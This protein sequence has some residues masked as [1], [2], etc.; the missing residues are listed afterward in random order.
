MGLWTD[1][2]EP[3]DNWPSRLGGYLFGGGD[4]KTTLSPRTMIVPSFFVASEL[5]TSSASSRT[6]FMCW[7][8]LYSLPLTLRPPFSWTRTTLFRLSSK[9]FAATSDIRDSTGGSKCHGVCTLLKIVVE[10]TESIC[11]TELS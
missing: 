5:V 2:A 8:K 3:G 4:T 11:Q 1:S 10:E 9:I 6:K 7:S